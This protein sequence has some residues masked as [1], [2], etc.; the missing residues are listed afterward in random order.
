MSEEFIYISMFEAA[1]LP[2]GVIS[3]KLSGACIRVCNIYN[4]MSRY[5][6]RSDSKTTYRVMKVARTLQSTVDPEYYGRQRPQ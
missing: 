5:S 2:V 3:K 4:E 1:N 6:S